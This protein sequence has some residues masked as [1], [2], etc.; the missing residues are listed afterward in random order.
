VWQTDGDLNTRS[1]R[2][3]VRLEPTKKCSLAALVAVGVMLAAAT[4]APAAD[5]IEELLQQD[6]ASGQNGVL[7]SDLN[8]L[9][10]AQWEYYF[11]VGQQSDTLSPLVERASKKPTRA[12]YIWVVV[13]AAGFGMAIGAI[14]AW[15]SVRRIMRTPMVPVQMEDLNVTIGAYAGYGDGRP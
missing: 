14:V 13:I 6:E 12:F 7:R 1:T 3:D 10:K 8:A 4:L 9:T 11:K 5:T 15:P 2:R